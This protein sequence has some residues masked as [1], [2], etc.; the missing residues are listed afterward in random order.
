MLI[1][2]IVSVIV[3]RV[4]AT[5]DDIGLH[6]DG[7]WETVSPTYNDEHI[8]FTFTGD[9]FSM[10]TESM[11][12]DAE[13]NDIE[14]IREF[15]LQHNGAIVSAI[16]MDDGSFH[17]RITADGTFAIDGNTILLVMAEGLTTNLPFYW[18]S[19]AIIINGDRYVQR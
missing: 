7:I 8:T 17:L 12:H 4:T 15:H 9:S 1:F 3:D 18:E 14:A 11:I 13:P 2:G 19:D 16:D 6:I 5:N 10:L